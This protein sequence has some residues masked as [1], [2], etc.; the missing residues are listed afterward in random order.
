MKP[1]RWT[2]ENPWVRR[3]GWR[4]LEKISFSGKPF[5]AMTPDVDPLQEMC[6][7]K[8]FPRVMSRSTPEAAMRYVDREYPLK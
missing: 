7:R 1:P 4:I 3:D 2:G 6:K 5:F 8:G